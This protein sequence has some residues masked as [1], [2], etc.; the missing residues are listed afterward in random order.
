MSSNAIATMVK[1]LETLPESA[2]ERLVDYVREQME[3]LQDEMRWDML[4][5]QTQNQLVAAA[6]R[7]R[8]QIAEGLAKPMDLEK[9]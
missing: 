8:K 2:Q 9:L 3:E 1:M 4:F 7:A 5:S 6:R